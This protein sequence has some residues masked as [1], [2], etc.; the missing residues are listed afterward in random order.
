MARV[1]PFI[2]GLLVLS[3]ATGQLASAQPPYKPVKSGQTAPPDS[4]PLL[5]VIQAKLDTAGLALA[6]QDFRIARD[7]LKK[8][9]ELSEQVLKANPASRRAAVALGVI[10]F[11]E[12]AAGDKK[13]FE[14]SSNWL[15]KVV[16]SDPDA[17]LGYRFLAHAYA[18][19]SKLRETIIN[20]NLALTGDLDSATVRELTELRRTFQDYFLVNWYE[21]GKYYESPAAKL[22]RINVQNNYAVELVAQITPQ[23]EQELAAKGLQ[24]L[25][26]S[27]QISTDAPAKQYLQ[28][29]VD[30]LLSKSPGGPPF[31]YTVDVVESSAVNAMAF[32]GKIF[33]NTGLIK[34]CESEA[35]LITV[36][37]HEIA[38]VYAH[39]SARA[40]Q[41]NWQKQQLTS[42]LL[43]VA[44]VDN[45]NLK[46]QLI[47]L[48]ATVGLELLARGYSRNEEK[49][50]DKYGT[51]LA[52][53]A[54]Y[55]PSLMTKFFLRLYEANPKQPF[56]WLSTH[57][58]TTERIEYTSAYLES[59]PL[60]QEMQLDSQEF[61]D[62]KARLK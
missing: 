33:V 12:G 21:Y 38:H 62:L 52:F 48:G 46:E 34:F 9:R 24:A 58:P 6:R 56:K 36:L 44:G 47:T 4:S 14:R 53:N 1:A 19:Q 43:H 23:F 2:A 54:G 11:Y 27:L 41:S 42:T 61:K 39:H 15:Q 17:V 10:Y 13:A 5:A 29:L 20:A 22:T 18:R 37:S 40:L 8:G 57:P 32:P 3:T 50:A 51:H 45:S 28:K 49:E 26:S 31:T 7:H 55:N 35:E 59:F 16:D 60:E 30:K 25:G